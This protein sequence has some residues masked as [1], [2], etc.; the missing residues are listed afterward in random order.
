[1]RKYY[2]SEI[3]ERL[4]QGENNLQISKLSQEI[5]NLKKQFA[6]TDYK[7]SKMIQYE[8]MGLELPYSWEEI[9]EAAEAIRVQIRERE[10]ELHNLLQLGE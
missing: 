7:T 9:Y 2:P 8:N 1:M 10:K 6:D 4:K 5:E 3:I